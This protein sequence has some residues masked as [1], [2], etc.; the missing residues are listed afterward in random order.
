MI[1]QL[2]GLWFWWHPFTA[3]DLLLEFS[4]CVPMNRQ[5]HP[6]LEWPKGEYIFNVFLGELL[7]KN[8]RQNLRPLWIP[9]NLKATSENSS[10]STL[11]DFILKKGNLV[12]LFIYSFT[13]WLVLIWSMSETYTHLINVWDLVLR[14]LP[15]SVCLFK[16]NRFMYFPIVSRFG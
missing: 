15:L 13:C 2:F 9:V 8:K 7:K 6:D 1:Y 14:A 3:R 12:F 16:M 5:T 10:R 11:L 4:K